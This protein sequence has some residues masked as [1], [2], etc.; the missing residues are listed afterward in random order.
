LKD[1]LDRKRPTI[2]TGRLLLKKNRPRII[3]LTLKT[4]PPEIH[5]HPSSFMGHYLKKSAGKQ[6]TTEKQKKKHQQPPLV[7]APGGPKAPTALKAWRKRPPTTG[8]KPV[9]NKS[10]PS[11]RG[12]GGTP[13]PGG[14]GAKPPPPA[15]KD[16]DFSLPLSLETSDLLSPHVQE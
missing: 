6:E 10:H 3:D 11:P 9:G 15:N 14:G 1:H 4:P 13:A 2:A 16:R 8:N 7:Q 12:Q 5:Q